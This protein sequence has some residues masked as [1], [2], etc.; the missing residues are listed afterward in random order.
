M[1]DYLSGYKKRISS[2]GI[3]HY[4]RALK[5]KQREF[6]SYFKN[7]LNKEPCCIEGKDAEAVFQDH[8]QSNNKDL[9]DDKYVILQMIQKQMWAIISDGETHNG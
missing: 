1:T 7:T 5:H 3:N 8:S 6:A 2:M 9:S 4:E